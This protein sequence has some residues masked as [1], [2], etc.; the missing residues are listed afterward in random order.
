LT[1]LRVNRR[2]AFF[3][4]GLLKSEIRRHAAI[5]GTLPGVAS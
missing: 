1:K 4:I 2:R 5:L 3:E